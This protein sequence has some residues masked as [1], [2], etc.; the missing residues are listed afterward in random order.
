MKRRPFCESIG[1]PPDAL[2]PVPSVSTAWTPGDWRR[3]WKGYGSLRIGDTSFI[4]E[5][6]DRE[7]PH[8]DKAKGWM[9]H[10]ICSACDHQMNRAEAAHRIPK[11]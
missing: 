6:C 3:W 2:F 11:P 4:C 9:W 10:A 1:P 5:V 7:F 8:A